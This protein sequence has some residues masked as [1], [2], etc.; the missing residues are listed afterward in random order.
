MTNSDFIKSYKVRCISQIDGFITLNKEYAV[1]GHNDENRR[2]VIIDD[3]GREGWYKAERFETCATSHD[4]PSFIEVDELVGEYVTANTQILPKYV[5]MD[6]QTFV[7]FQDSLYPRE[8]NQTVS[9]PRLSGLV[10]NNAP[11]GVGVLEV[12]TDKR[13]VEVVG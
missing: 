10:L 1:I 4:I 12:K 6:T 3:T 9:Q 11:W 13:L 7:G 5:L 2:V 8:R